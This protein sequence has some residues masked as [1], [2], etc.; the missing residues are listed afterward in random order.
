MDESGSKGAQ[1]E[2][3]SSVWAPQLDKDHFW[4]TMVLTRFGAICGFKLA[5]FQGL[6]GLERGQNCSTWAQDGLIPIVCAPQIAPKYLRNNTFLINFEPIFGPKAAHFKASCASGVARRA[7]NGLKKG[8]FH[9][10]RHPKRSRIMFGK[11]H[12]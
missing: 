5:H 4:K 11:T 1:N 10:F 9:L 2:L 8:S 7:C 12:F 6:V 3:Y